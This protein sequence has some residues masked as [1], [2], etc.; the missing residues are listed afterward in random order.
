MTLETVKPVIMECVSCGLCRANCPMLEDVKLESATARGKL[1]ICYSLLTGNLQ[2]SAKVAERLFQCTACKACTEVCFSMLDIPKV[3]EAARSVLVE[4]GLVPKTIRDML[5]STMK[6]GNPWSQPKERRTNWLKDLE[7]LNLKILSDKE[8][9]ETIYFVGCTPSYD[10]RCQEIAKSIVKVLSKVGV[11][12]NILGNEELCCG[13][14][15]LR[16]GE[17]GL[18]DMLAEKN[19]ENFKRHHA[20]RIVTTSPHCYNT[21]K[22]EYPVENAEIEIQHYTQ[23]LADLIDKE[24]I[25][26]SKRL[27][28][29]VTYH[30]PCF[31]GRYNGVYEEPRKILESIPGLTLIEMDRAKKNSFC[32]G[33]GGGRMWMEETSD[34]RPSLNRA[35]EAVELKPDIIVTACPF[36]LIN[37]QDAVKVINKEKEVQVMDIAELVKKAVYDENKRVK[38]RFQPSE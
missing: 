23:F 18:F 17:K 22:N 9:T 11:D 37:M 20:E 7:K 19:L 25:K 14:S 31:L 34:T 3:V 27:N 38:T 12:F 24:K 16:V 15:A 32:C 2:L 8:K 10:H 13:D 28:K 5:I 21:F 36:C 29:M 4:K 35:R 30:D 26:F 33:G 6:Y 1:I